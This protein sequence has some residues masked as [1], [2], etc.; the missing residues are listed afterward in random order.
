MCRPRDDRLV[1]GV[2]AAVAN[3][4]EVDAWA[5]RAALV[6]LSFVGG[7]GILLYIA[8]WLWVPEE[9]GREP[10]AKK[11]LA[12]S[13]TLALAGLTASA[14]V[15]FL[16]VVSVLGTPALLGY[17]SPGLLGLAGLVAI[18]RHAGPGDRAALQ[19][20]TGALGSQRF[21]TKSTKRGARTGAPGRNQLLFGVARLVAG[22]ALV[23]AGTSTLI[24]P[25]HFNRTDLT[26]LLAA[27]AVLAGAALVLAPWWLRLAQEL[28][29]ERRQRA[30]AEERAEMASHL[31]DSVLQTLA[32]IQRSASD[33]Q[34]VRRLAR[35][36][37]RELR[38]WLFG[39][40]SPTT[41]DQANSREAPTQLL[42]AALA[43]LQQE[44]EMNHGLRAEVV[45]VGDAPL[46]ERLEALVAATKEAVVNAAKWSGEDVVSIYA[47]VEPATVSVF[48][49]DRGK[50]FDPSSVAPDRKGLSESVHA[51]MRRNG[52]TSSV[53][54]A[55][56]EGTEV[57]LRMPRAP[58]Q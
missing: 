8:A 51:R 6:A 38:S 54:S 7:T 20:L 32:L 13:L 11:A 35:A 37:E 29:A 34:Q 40:P 36:Q 1:A 19:R 45:T 58:G 27:L 17:L 52:G 39:N 43:A 21:A 23:A 15:V 46:D 56:G 18:W 50:G 10:L 4:L 33:P 44:V 26:V 49:R 24:A 53:R 41:G 48:V 28:S 55:P 57:A 30:R 14:F 12:D 31:H 47:E 2:A 25:R 3:R 16:V 22:A 5:V 9:G 42:S